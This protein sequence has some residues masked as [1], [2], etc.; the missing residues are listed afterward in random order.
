MMSCTHQ[1]VFFI[2]YAGSR[3]FLSSILAIIMF[4]TVD[5]YNTE[6]LRVEANL[7]GKPAAIAHI[8]FEMHNKIIFCVENEGH[9]YRDINVSNV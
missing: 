3:L 5:R 6:N 1:D 8:L 2:L 7:P 4:G 9:D